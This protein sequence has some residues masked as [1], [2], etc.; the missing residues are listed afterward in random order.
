M[1]IKEN[2]LI[3]NKPTLR[4]ERFYNQHRTKNMTSIPPSSVKINEKP[5]TELEDEKLLRLLDE[6][7]SK[8]KW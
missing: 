3:L 6:K 8:E 5:W 2:N 7:R 1:L 4:F